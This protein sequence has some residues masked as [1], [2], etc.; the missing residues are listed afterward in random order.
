M[1]EEL[2]AIERM[3]EEVGIIS[4]FNLPTPS[5]VPTAIINAAASSAARTE[6]A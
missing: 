5:D 4:P 2:A 3:N 6:T 1:V